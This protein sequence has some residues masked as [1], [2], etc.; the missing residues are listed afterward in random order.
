MAHDL[1]PKIAP[2]LIGI[3]IASMLAAVMSSCD[4][5]MITSSALF[6][7]NVYRPFVAPDK[8]D[9]HYISVGRV[10]AVIVV[11]GGIFVAF[12]L[13]NVVKG[14]ELFWKIAAMMGVAFWVGFF[15]RKATAAAAWASTFAGFAALLFT[16]DIDFLGWSFNDLFA[17]NLPDFMLWE[18]KLYLPWQMIIYLSVGF[19]TCIIVSL[20]TRPTDGAVL[21]RIYRCLR[22]PVSETEPEV[23]PF[24]LPEGMQ[25]A[26]RK[27]LIDHPDFEIMKPNLMSIA[28][29]I[30]A[31]V[32]VG[33]L[34]GLFYLCLM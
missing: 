25:P 15:W 14:L 24:T 11:T 2:G 5:F 6:T 27:V 13:Q 1:L 12:Q 29:F 16:S 22:T 30:V 20:F 31:W 21:D 18:N 33:G 19:I 32:A 26:A 17:A 3:F 8:S 7:E 4:S 9:K 23:E 34:I 10:A 28:G